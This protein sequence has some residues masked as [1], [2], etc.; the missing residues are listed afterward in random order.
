[1]GTADPDLYA[2][3]GV[4]RDASP[5]QIVGAYRGLL[6][7]LHP[8][9][10]PGRGTTSQSDSDA[11]LQAVLHAYEVLRAPG[12]RAAYDEVIRNQEAAVVRPSG[13]DRAQPPIR[14]TPV[15]WHPA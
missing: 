1:M 7:R 8:D 5:A 15:R 14:V 9:T 2:T 10:R 3:L 6:R 4:D 13:A 11:T 12:R